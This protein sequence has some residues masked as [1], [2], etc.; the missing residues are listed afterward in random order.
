MMRP[1]LLPLD[2]MQLPH[3]L[4]EDSDS[5]TDDESVVSSD[6]EN[7]AMQVH[8]SLRAPFTFLQDRRRDRIDRVGDALFYGAGAA[9]MRSGYLFL[10]G[11]IHQDQ[12]QIVRS[13]N[14]FGMA[15]TMFGVGLMARS[16]NQYRH[17]RQL[18]RQEAENMADPLPQR[19]ANLHLSEACI[20]NAIDL[21]TFAC[22]EAERP[23]MNGSEAV[24]LAGYLRTLV[25]CG[26]DEI[27]PLLRQAALNA[28]DDPFQLLT[29][30]LLV[31]RARAVD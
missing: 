13:V 26:N 18:R 22:H 9:L 25:C 23:P 31:A 16:Y 24:C 29:Q 28:H 17:L 7:G 14:S 27:L 30:L 10:A 21:V 19:L 1:R 6:E 4:G 8:A 11:S 2:N 20:F 12:A 3:R 15:T 5:I